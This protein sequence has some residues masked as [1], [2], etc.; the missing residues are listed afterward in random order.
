MRD[1][2]HGRGSLSVSREHNALLTAHFVHNF[3]VYECCF[4]QYNEIMKISDLLKEA[5]L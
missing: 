4:F 3:Q 2:A 5:T 1:N